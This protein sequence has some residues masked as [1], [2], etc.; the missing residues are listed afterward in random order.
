MAFRSE[1]EL[2][3]WLAANG[4]QRCHVASAQLMYDVSA[5]WYANRTEFSWIRHDA[6]KARAILERHGLRGEV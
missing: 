6:A 2:E 4:K 1:G 5:D 3:R